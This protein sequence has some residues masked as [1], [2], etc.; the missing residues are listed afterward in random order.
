MKT[1][2]FQPRLADPVLKLLKTGVRRP[3]GAWDG[4]RCAER[5]FAIV[6]FFV[7]G[8]LCSALLCARS[9]ADDLRYNL[10]GELQLVT[11]STAQAPTIPSQPRGQVAPVGGTVI[12]SISAIGSPP[13]TFQWQFNSNNIPGATADTLFL[14]NLTPAQFGAYRV[15]VSNPSGSV[16]SSN[17]L[18]QLDSDRDGLADAWETNF[19]TSI[20]NRSGFEDYDQDGALDRDEFLE[21]TNPRFAS[22]SVNPRLMI[23]SD[24]GEVFATPNQPFY[25]N[26]QTVT[27]TGVP[28]PGLQFI[29]YLGGVYLGDLSYLIRTNPAQIRFGG[30]GM[31]GTQVIRAFFGL[32]IPD[33]LD[34]TNSWRIDDAGWFGQSKITHDGVDAVQSGRILG[35][36]LAM[37]ELNITL[38][39]EG[40]MTFWW[41]VDGTPANRLQFYRNNRLR[42]G[43]IGTNTDWQKRTYYLG[44]GNNLVQWLYRNYSDE[45]SEYNGMFEAPA[46]AAWVDEVSYGVWPDPALDADSDGMRDI[47][48]LRHFDTTDI[49]ANADEDR[50]GV[51]NRD[52]FIDGTDPSSNGSYLPRLTVITSGG[53]RVTRNPDYAKYTNETVRLEA[54]PEPDNYFVIWG[55]AVSGTNTTNTVRMNTHRT[56]T[57]EFGLPLEI[58]LDTPALAWTRTG[59]IG[60]FGQTNVSSD[61]VDAAQAGPIERGQQSAMETSVSGPGTLIFWWKAQCTANVNYGRFFIDG[62]EQ[63]EKITGAIDWHPH[64]VLLPAGN[65]LLRWNYTNVG[66]IVSLT[67]TIWVDR[68]TFSSSTVPLE[69]AAQPVDLL[70]P[71]DMDA[72]FRIGASGTPPFRYQ[73]FRNGVSLGAAG[74]NSGLTLTRVTSAQA[75]S[76]S[77]QVSNGAQT[78]TSRSATLT[79]VPTPPPNDDFADRTFITG[80]NLLLGY[81]FLASWEFGQPNIATV[82]GSH[83]VW[84]NWIAPAEGSYQLNITATNTSG[85][86]GAAIY[87]GTVLTNLFEIA[88][89]L[90]TNSNPSIGRLSLPFNASAGTSYSIGVDEIGG[91]VFFS[92]NIT[93]AVTE[94]PA[95]LST[96]ITR[97]QIAFNM[98]AP[99]GANYVIESSNDLQIWTLVATG[100][101]PPS[102]VLNFSDVISREHT[103]RFYR[104]RIL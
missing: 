10:S 20:T 24:Y 45:V 86:F 22:S 8:C 92:L 27:L 71:E 35:V 88:S 44:A 60:F 29:G 62:V 55:G 97:D 26:G 98:S 73:W 99:S 82:N 102:G 43:E 41:K 68:V 78:I 48:E 59:S 56:V 31:F 33:S 89:S 9:Y 17:A 76:Y 5:V 42:S 34:V 94:R 81:T 25:T 90:A 91:G 19:F 84:W 13:P 67:N 49:A 70:V 65:H 61:G 83:S 74:T 12:F 101:V 54:L 3:S 51:S 2:C 77:V 40:T 96:V 36:P 72:V 95:L 28:D 21:G 1:R 14:P 11:N 53:G 103:A 66:A 93:A 37:L 85:K 4:R 18:L 16:T 52:E 79:I 75:G 64:S 38:T 50:D 58:A 6:G 87:T 46:D 32:P 104:I 80:T 23:I 47:W 100:V 7:T 57:A 39:N 63:P 15:A 30:P 69:I